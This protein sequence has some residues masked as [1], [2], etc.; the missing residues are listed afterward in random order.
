MGELAPYFDRFRNARQV[1]LQRGN[2]KASRRQF[3]PL[4]V[5]QF[6][7]ILAQIALIPDLRLLTT[8]G[9]L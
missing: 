2:R 4:M 7:A 8:C 3:V 1:R 6:S 9:V 5:S